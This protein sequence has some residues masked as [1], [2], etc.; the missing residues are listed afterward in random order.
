MGMALHTLPEPA[1]PGDL[2]AFGIERKLLKYRVTS[3]S[4]RAGER[5]TSR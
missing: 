2:P 4:R 5:L 1:D 3:L